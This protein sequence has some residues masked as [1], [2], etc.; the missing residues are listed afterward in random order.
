V[1]VLTVSEGVIKRNPER[2][3]VYLKAHRVCINGRHGGDVGSTNSAVMEGVP[4]HCI[5]MVIIHV[6]TDAFANSGG[7]RISGH[8]EKGRR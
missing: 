7:K 4:K 8:G 6:T 5:A 1:G 2:F 3:P